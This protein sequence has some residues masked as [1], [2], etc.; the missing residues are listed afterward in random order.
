MNLNRVGCKEVLGYHPL[1]VPKKQ[2]TELMKRAMRLNTGTRMA[3]ECGPFTI[4]GLPS[5][6]TSSRIYRGRHRSVTQY[7]DWRFE[8]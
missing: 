3:I 7:S 1:E 4:I 2:A 8:P 6:C 5:G